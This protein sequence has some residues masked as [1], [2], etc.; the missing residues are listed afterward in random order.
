MTKTKTS[1]FDA[2]KRALDERKA[3]KR[4]ASGEIVQISARLHREDWLKMADL[5]TREG[6]SHQEQVILGL[7]LLFAQ[8][9][10]APPQY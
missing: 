7:G 5:R 2:A 3:K 10:I 6:L 4:T 9:G 1:D 8:Y